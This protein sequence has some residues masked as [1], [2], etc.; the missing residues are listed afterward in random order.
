MYDAVGGEMRKVIG[1]LVFLVGV[2]GLSYWASVQHGPR[3]ERQVAQAADRVVAGS[4]HGAA[5]RTS[6]RDIVV[7][8]V[9][10]SPAER[11]ALLASLQEVT[12]R[13]VVLDELTV[14]TP[15]T[16]YV[17][18]GALAENGARSISGLVPSDRLRAALT[19]VPGV[20][21]LEVAAGAPP[22]W[23]E[24]VAQAQAAL[25]PLNSG[26]WALEGSRLILTGEA[27]TEDE[28]AA[29]QEALDSLP[30][31]IELQDQITVRLSAEEIDINLRQE[32]QSLV[33]DLRHPITPVVQNRVITLS[34]VVESEAE[35][36]AILA[37]MRGLPRQT[38]VVDDLR[39]LPRAQPYVT[40]GVLTQDGALQ[41]TGSVPTEADR[42]R[43]AMNG[44]AAGL[45]LATGAPETWRATMAG[46]VQALGGLQSGQMQLEDQ[47]LT[48]TGTARTAAERNGVL[49][50]LADL[51]DAVEISDEIAVATS[52]DA[53]DAELQVQASARVA[54]AKHP[55]IVRATG[56][57]IIARGLVESDQERRAVLASLRAIP[58]Q[59]GVIDQL[60]VLPRPTPYI[61]RGQ[62]VEGGNIR[63]TGAVPS[64]RL[65]A[66]LP[67][68]A[69][70]GDLSLGAGAPGSWP[71]AVVIA[72]AALGPLIDGSWVLSDQTLT[73]TGEAETDMEKTEALT[74]LRSLPGDIT[75]VD[76]ITVRVSA[77]TVDSQI[78]EA[79]EALTAGAE[80]G[81]RPEVSNRIV[82]LRGTVGTVSERDAL[83]QEAGRIPR[84]SRVVDSL[85]ILPRLTPYIT[86]GVENFRGEI[87]LSGGVPSRDAQDAI[88]GAE[89]RNMTLASGAPDL[90]A[91]T[92]PLANRAMG[93]M[94][95]GRWRLTDTTLEVF[96]TVNTPDQQ[97]AALSVFDVRPEGLSLV[98]QI[99]VLDD[100]TPVRFGIQYDAVTGAAVS[101][102]LPFGMTPEQVAQGLDLPQ[103]AGEVNV[104]GYDRALARDARVALAALAKHLPQLET[105]RM[106][107]NEGAIEVDGLL[108]PGSDLEEIAR[109]VRVDL[110]A[111][112]Q[113]SLRVAEAADLPVRGTTRTNAATGVAEVLA[114]GF[115][116]PAIGSFDPT[117]EVC[118]A[119]AEDIMRDVNIRF[120]TGSARLSPDSFDDL[121][122]MASL[123]QVCV[124]Q[125][126]L[127]AIVG[128]HTDSVGAAESNQRL[129]E[130]R[131]QSV[132]DALVER[133]IP[134]QFLRAVGYGETQP[135]EDNATEAGRAANR[136][137]TLEWA[138][139]P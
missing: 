90:W 62:R 130:A 118:A 133:G 54:G 15:V 38:D 138:E 66:A 113:V 124:M 49:A 73:V 20:D 79:V 89:T 30:A 98:P 102:K 48:L 34:G 37:A 64:E 127:R 17:T 11:D 76:D 39:V 52:V 55:I 100:G 112:A 82:I 121:N 91:A 116:V 58:D 111:N 110:R 86:E 22:G 5:T 78:Q 84:V 43:L 120:V 25:G 96:G 74:R 53:R 31:G 132:R 131:A 23:S 125:G 21:S 92:V 88:T 44:D 106:D 63:L 29:A 103:V 97:Q 19:P 119:Q 33:T 75:V 28:R 94:D 101:G 60:Q 32:A 50:A 36:S 126:G 114:G 136:R 47:R 8:G 80:H 24:T 123:L 68:T 71:Q 9:A 77:Q 59:T 104:N 117:P 18:R 1:G 128:G 57:Q 105:L 56:G 109:A 122:T 40:T 51:P 42:T 99:T 139:I 26:T 69:L 108:S 83:L 46:A 85:E 41:F 2:G 70:A 65:R 67:D 61:T 45:S 6:G 16:P 12:G 115:W 10:D 81:V 129:S 27:E 134:S 135:V 107:W 137:T 7:Q 13:R 95:A 3:I 93:Q 14:L 72:N 4:V 35:K 87:T